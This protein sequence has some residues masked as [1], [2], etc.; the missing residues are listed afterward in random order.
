MADG[1]LLRLYTQ[2]EWIK[3]VCVCVVFVLCVCVC[4]DYVSVLFLYSSGWEP[5]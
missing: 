1:G 5:L 2:L 4:V 3:V